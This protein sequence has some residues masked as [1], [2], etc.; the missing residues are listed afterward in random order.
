LREIL[1]NESDQERDRIMAQFNSQMRKL[2]N[3]MNDERSEMEDKVKAKLAAKKRLKEELEKEKAVTKELDRITKSHVRFNFFF[4]TFK[5]IKNI[6]IVV[7][8][9]GILNHMVYLPSC[10]NVT[11]VTNLCLGRA[12]TRSHS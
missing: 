2:N 5:Q 3:R 8:S 11:P 4:F 7:L 1:K 10:N 6:L 12:T 9:Y